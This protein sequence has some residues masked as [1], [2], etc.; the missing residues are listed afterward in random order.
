MNGPVPEWS[1]IEAAIDHRV[2][3]MR[4]GL[5]SEVYAALYEDEAGARMLAALNV[6]L[7]R[8]S[9]DPEGAAKIWAEREPFEPVIPRPGWLAFLYRMLDHVDT[10]SDARQRRPR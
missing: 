2:D 4:R 3:E 1:I 10:W 6:R 9:W 8:A 7:P 5:K